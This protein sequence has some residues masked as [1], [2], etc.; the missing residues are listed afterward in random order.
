MN[1]LPISSFCEPSNYSTAAL[2]Q[3]NTMQDPTQIT[4]SRDILSKPIS[5]TLRE[6]HT[7]RLPS[8][9]TCFGNLRVC[10]RSEGERSHP[11]VALSSSNHASFELVKSRRTPYKIVLSGDER[12]KRKKRASAPEK[13]D[14]DEKKKE[15]ESKKD[16][17][18]E[19]VTE[20]E[21]IVSTDVIGGDG[22][23]WEDWS[24][25]NSTAVEAVAVRKQTGSKV[26]YSLRI[27]RRHHQGRERRRG[28]NHS[29]AAKAGATAEKKEKKKNGDG[30]DNTDRRQGTVWED[31]GS[32][33]EG[34]EVEKDSKPE[35]AEDG[36]NDEKQKKK[37]NKEP[38]AKADAAMAAQPTQTIELNYAPLV[39]HLT[40]L[41]RSYVKTLTLLVSSNDD[42]SIRIYQPLE[43]NLGEVREVASWE[44]ACQTP[45]LYSLF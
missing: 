42:S 7:T 41:P 1:N 8:P 28:S 23:N 4:L 31:G 11:F 24:D 32:M 21:L 25:P 43:N 30:G 19:D 40:Y 15:D 26:S 20:T 39:L 14:D 33:V 5:F 29:R 35:E 27:S 45:L 9:S 10:L 12:A 2:P 36:K 13:E 6:C 37:T 17:K 16:D 22:E 44:W 3:Y 18:K 38:E 34:A